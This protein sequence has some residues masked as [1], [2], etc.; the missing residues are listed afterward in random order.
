MVEPLNEASCDRSL[1]ASLSVLQYI[2]GSEILLLRL[3][4]RIGQWGRMMDEVNEEGNR[5]NP[6][7][8]LAGC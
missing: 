3:M 2:G 1:F 7:V 8:S 4:L 6:L 5:L